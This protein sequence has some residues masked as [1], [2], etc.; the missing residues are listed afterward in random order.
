MSNML[1]VV[2]EIAIHQAVDALRA[3]AITPN[4]VS[5]D[6]GVEAAQ[7]NAR[8]DVPVWHDLPVQ[9]V[10]AGSANTPS[11]LAPRVASVTLDQWKEVRFALSDKEMA[12]IVNGSIPKVMERAV[13][14]LADN[15]DKYILTALKNAAG[16]GFVDVGAGT[17]VANITSMGR[18][19]D[20]NLIPQRGRQMVIATTTKEELITLTTFHEANKV[21]DQGTALRDASLGRAFGYDIFMNQNLVNTVTPGT[22][23]AAQVNG[24][25]SAGTRT[26]AIDTVTGTFKKG[27][28]ITIA[29]NP[30]TFVVLAD[31]AGAAGNL[32]IGP[33]LR[34]DTL[35]NA[36][37]ALATGWSAVTAVR[38]LAFDAESFAFASRPLN[39]Q[40]TPGVIVQMSTD[41]VS[42][43]S[44]RLTVEYINKQVVWSLDILYG[45]QAIEE[46]R[47]GIMGT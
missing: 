29:T 32:S 28:Q 17:T 36:A 31:Y 4:L 16:G 30:G 19:Q 10:A 15:V 26:L 14:A 2:S 40:L 47:I 25:Q 3:N 42:G 33:G 24:N 27:D 44:L 46:Q 1:A 39:T 7:Q 22:A 11:N 35:D 6:I 43:L 18:Q 9:D 23:S 8:I 21:G 20:D 34:V 5:R 12:E 13:K 38:A 41:P 45:G 37:V